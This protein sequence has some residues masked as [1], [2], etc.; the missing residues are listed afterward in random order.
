MERHTR[1]QFIALTGCAVLVVAL[2]A[3]P[4]TPSSARPLQQTVVRPTLTA[5]PPGGAVTP[6]PAAESLAENPSLAGYVWV[7]GDVFVPAVGVPVR[8]AGA[9][10]EL[11]T[12]TDANGYYQFEQ[13]G[14]DVGLLN[15]AGNGSAWKASVKDVAL[16]ARPG[17]SLR[18]NFSASQSSPAKGPSLLSVSVRPSSVGAGQS[19]TVTINATNRTAQKLSGV[20][21]SQA[22]PAGLSISGLTT[23]RGDALSVDRLAMAN[24]GD[25]APGD[26]ATLTI[27]ALGSN[28]GGPQGSLALVAS[29]ISREGVTVQS[30][31]SVMGTGGPGM[32]PVTG[33]A[34]WLAGVGLALAALVAVT[35]VARQWSAR[36]SARG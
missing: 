4:A 34:E 8:F 22:L 18:A 7:N 32:L 5:T 13:V 15:V 11:A 1:R 3:L 12:V 29:L 35:R 19:V 14:Q 6:A 9:G 33:L 30:S 25:M 2:L 31:T 20:W 28:D 21:L 27:V 16:S 23:N 24:L 17:L 10:F 36:V 26:S